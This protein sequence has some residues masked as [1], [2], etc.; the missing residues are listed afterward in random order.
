MKQDKSCVACAFVRFREDVSSNATVIAR[1][2]PTRVHLRVLHSPRGLKFSGGGLVLASARSDSGA[3]VTVDPHARWCGARRASRRAC[4]ASGRSWELTF[5]RRLAPRPGHAENP[6]S[7]VWLVRTDEQFYAAKRQNVG[8]GEV[9]ALVDEAVAWRKASLDC[10]VLAEL[11]DVFVSREAPCS[12]TFLHEYCERRHVPKKPPSEPVLLTLVADLADAA[13]A[14]A[15]ATG[16]PHGNITYDSVLVDDKGRARLVGFGAQRSARLVAERP[17]PEQDLLDT[18]DLIFHLVVGRPLRGAAPPAGALPYEP[19][20]VTLVEGLLDAGASGMRPEEAS[21]RARELGAELRAPVVDV[22]E[23]ATTRDEIVDSLSDTSAVAPDVE[24]AVEKL[25]TGVDA[26]GA[27][28]AV[29]AALERDAP[30]AAKALF[31]TLYNCPIAKDPL[32]TMRALTLLHNLMLDGPDALLDT[33]RANDKFLDWIES[34]WSAEAVSAVI[35]DRG[36]GDEPH[37][38]C[39]SFAGGELAFYTALLR[40]KAR[41]HMLAA[42]GFSGAWERTGK[43]AADGGDVLVA[44]RRKVVG[45]MADL[46]EMASEIGSTFARASDAETALKHASLRAIVDECC[47]AFNAAHGL[48]AETKS[49]RDAEKLVPGFSRLWDAA[50]ALLGAVKGIRS[51][52][53]DDWA[54]QFAEDS[55]PDI[56]KEAEFRIRGHAP[57][58]VADDMPRD[59]WEATEKMMG[60]VDADAEDKPKKKKGEAEAEEENGE[61]AN[62][63][64]EEATE[65][66]TAVVLHGA[67]DAEQ[68]A[69]TTMFGDLLKLDGGDTTELRDEVD[70]RAARASG[71]L[72]D[73]EALA[74]AFGAPMPSENSS[75][76]YDGYDDE[77]DGG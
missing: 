66:I 24:K 30:R 56:V 3:N 20:V 61:G 14:V 70:P 34:T 63:D 77:G 9:D 49:I 35:A 2:S 59:G 51:A 48:A 47:R 74:S 72:T 18:A 44:R 32:A 60:D 21:A 4:R 19:P 29:L 27:Y 38:A 11:V 6:A 5:E 33:T 16:S 62:G 36:G 46:A 17:P 31:K 15:R 28:S 53:A 8:R 45:G 42:G 1:A 13:A 57:P 64:T 7:S 71:E 52:G 67:G 73:G 50:T 41:F 23:R 75:G 43:I 65:E 54:D 55:P 69:V 12:V 10:D 22:S 68:A 58:E 76:A 40:R 25:T 37:S 39:N 26:G